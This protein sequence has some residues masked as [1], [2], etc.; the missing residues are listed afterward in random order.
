MDLNPAIDSIF[1]IDCFETIKTSDSW[2]KTKNRKNG[3]LGLGDP[4]IHLGI[5]RG[6]IRHLGIQ[7][8]IHA[9]IWAYK[10]ASIHTSWHLFLHRLASFLYP[11]DIVWHPF[12]I[13]LTSFSIPFKSYDILVTLF[14][15]FSQYIEFCLGLDLW[16]AR[17]FRHHLSIPDV[18][19]GD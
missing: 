15:S 17:R 4:C 16:C 18:K 5:Q 10:G 19:M 9:Y 12:Y 14:F 13:F 7:R 8:G 3:N 2:V 1:S 6:S 11:F